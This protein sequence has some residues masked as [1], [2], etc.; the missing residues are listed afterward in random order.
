MVIAD[1]LDKAGL[2]AQESLESKYGKG[3]ASFIR[4]DLTVSHEVE[5]LF[6]EIVRKYNQLDIVINNAGKSRESVIFCQY[7]IFYINFYRYRI[8][9]RSW[10]EHPIQSLEEGS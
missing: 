7:V 8:V 1:V 9:W 6:R 2:E 3:R 10:R 4:V 5:G